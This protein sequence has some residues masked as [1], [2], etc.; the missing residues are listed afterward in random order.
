[1]TRV[2]LL[3]FV[4]I[5]C[6]YQGNAGAGTAQT[7]Y[8]KHKRSV[9]DVSCLGIDG[10]TVV[11]GSGFVAGDNHLVVT[12]A[13]VVKNAVSIVVSFS[14]YNQSSK[15]EVEVIDNAADVAVLRVKTA[16]A[17][18]LQFSPKKVEPGIDVF[19]IGSPLGLEATIAS[20]IVS[21]VRTLPN[22]LAY[23]Q[24]TVPASPGS[25]GCPLL[26]SLGRVVGMVCI[27]SSGAAQNVNFAISATMLK[28]YVDK[29]RKNQSLRGP[30]QTGETNEQLVTI[31]AE[32]IKGFDESIGDGD[33]RLSSATLLDL[34]IKYQL[35]PRFILAVLLTSSTPPSVDAL[36]VRT[37]SIRLATVFR[38]AARGHKWTDLSWRD[39]V[40]VL[41]A[42]RKKHIPPSYYTRLAGNV[43]TFEKNAISRYRQLCGANQR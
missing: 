38:S 42:Y 1:M 33:A 34:S 9:V 31:Y 36:T 15:A 2:R 37:T 14:G 28:P 21:A 19:T 16:L 24:T 40:K 12:C 6:S 7:I 10:K 39:L 32:A 17:S 22:G 30:E 41:A 26:D 20:G 43:T 4:L 11:C 13:H 18:P 27:A 8:I 3:I 35:D 23:I 29:A 25:S 5:L